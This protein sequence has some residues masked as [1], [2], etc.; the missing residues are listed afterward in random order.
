MAK[1]LIAD[2]VEKE[3]VKIVEN[4]ERSFALQAEIAKLQKTM[5]EQKHELGDSVKEKIAALREDMRANLVSNVD[6][7]KL[8]QDKE[9]VK[10][11][12]QVLKGE[13]GDKVSRSEI[14]DLFVQC[15]QGNSEACQLIQQEGKKGAEAA[16]PKEPEGLRHKTPAELMSCPDCNPLVLSYLKDNPADLEG[17]LCAPGDDQCRLRLK[18]YTQDELNQKVSEALEQKEKQEIEVEEEKKKH[19]I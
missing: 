18:L 12:L 4:D 19:W 2:S 14:N 15:L 5:V 1:Y 7:S 8:L 13:V 10:G 6:F 16:A 17:L 11:E 3:E 9:Q